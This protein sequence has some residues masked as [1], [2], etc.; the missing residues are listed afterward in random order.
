MSYSVHWWWISLK[1]ENQR[2]LEKTGVLNKMSICA[3][4]SDAVLI[5]I[6]LLDYFIAYVIDRDRS[7]W[8]H[9]D[10]KCSSSLSGIILQGLPLNDSRGLGEW[11]KKA[12]NL[13]CVAG[14]RKWEKEGV[15]QG[16]GG[17]FSC[18][19]RVTIVHLFF[20]SGLRS[21]LR[22]TQTPELCI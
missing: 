8:F 18:A 4:F 7:T 6:T 14:G 20:W 3:L 5:I 13:A 10:S 22:H 21:N 1:K 17:L 19:W 15:L 16:G 9:T 12:G 11:E 2:P